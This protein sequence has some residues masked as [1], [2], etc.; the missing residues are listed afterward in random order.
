MSTGIKNKK[1]L[2]EAVS[3]TIAHAVQDLEFGTITI[4]VHD[5]KIIQVEVTQKKR[6]D[7]VW[8]QGEGGGI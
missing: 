7:D 5:A 6:F 3:K 1:S 8:F 2:N 4:K